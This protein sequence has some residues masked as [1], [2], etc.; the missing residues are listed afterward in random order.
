MMRS[1]LLM[2]RNVAIALAVIAIGEA[3]PPLQALERWT[4]PRRPL[5]AWWM[6][7]ITGL[8]WLLLMGATLYRIWRGGA[9]LTRSEI[10]EQVGRVKSALAAPMAVARGWKVRL[11]KRAWGA[12]FSDEVSITQFKIAWRNQLWRQDSRWRGLFLMG[13][14]AML[15]ALGG[16]GLIIVLGAPGLKLLAGGA[17]LYA[18]TRTVWVFLRA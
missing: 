11:P 3:L 15:M 1:W 6:G 13:L 14:G 8:G 12:G 18:T 17:L 2:L 10:A 5:L 4:A 9:S 7:G 16:F